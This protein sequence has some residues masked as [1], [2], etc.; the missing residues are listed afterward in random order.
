MELEQNQKELASYIGKLLRDNFGR[1]PETV[2]V[3]IRKPFITVYLRNFLSPMEKVLISEKQDA[4]VQTSRDIL[5]KGLIPEIKAYMKVITG[6][7]IKEF[8][9]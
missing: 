6:F 7:S 5:M 2:F 9:Y 3:S 1:G 8:Y 4:L